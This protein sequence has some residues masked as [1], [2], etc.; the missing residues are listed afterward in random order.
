[1]TFGLPA[2]TTLKI[3]DYSIMK[4]ILILFVCLSMAYLS[5]ARETTF[6][7][8]SPDMA[9]KV[10]VTHTDA[11]FTLHVCHDGKPV[12]SIENISMTVDGTCWN[13]TSSFRK[14]VRTSTERELHP[15]APRKFSVLEDCHN[16]LSLEYRDYA[17]QVRVY[18]EGLAYRFC[19]KS[20]R[21]GTV[22]SESAEFVFPPECLS[23]TQLTDKL[24][25][26]FEF[27]Y[28]VQELASLPQDKFS[29]MPVMVR[30]GDCNIL[31][32]ETDLYGYA[33]SYLKPTGE[34]FGL[35]SV[36]YPAEEDWYEGSNKI[37]VTER[38]N[39]IV[40]T[41]LERNF[42]W[43]IAG[44]Y[45]SDAEILA[46]T[47]PDMV[48]GQ[49]EGDWSWVKPGK[50]LWDWWNG[51]NIYGVDFEAG[52]NT[53][54]YMYMVDYAAEH[55][56]EY[57]LIDEGWSAKES[58]LEL[59]PGVDIPAI[60]AHAAEK[61]VGVIL[62]S[63]WLNVDREMD[64]AFALLKSWGVAGLKIDWMDRNDAKMV[65][66]YER[67][68]KKAGEY[69]LLID[70]H[71]SYP[72]DGMEIRYPGLLTREGVYGLENSRWR[73]DCTPQHQ[74]SIP[75]IRQW[76]G[77]MDFTPGSML[78]A[79]PESFSPV[80]DEPMSMGT[81]CHQIAMY[82]VYESPL[83]MVSDSP[84][85]YDENPESLDFISK[86]PTVWDETVPLMGKIGEVAGV[87]RRSGQNWFIG[88]MNGNDAPICVEIP[89][90]FL[91]DGRY[92]MTLFSD[93]A[94]A[95]LNAKDHRITGSAVSASD[96]LK[97]EL[98]RNGGAA[99]MLEMDGTA[100]RK[101]AA[102]ASA[103][104]AELLSK[105]TLREKIAQLNQ[106]SL[107]E[108]DNVNNLGAPIDQV[109]AEIGSLIYFSD[110]AVLRNEMQRRAVEETRL[111][112]PILFGYDVIHGFRTIYPIPLAI[113]ASWNPG[114]AG[115][116]CRTAAQ[117][118]YDAGINWTFSPMVDI[119]RD[120]RWG[121]I[122]E[123]YGED[124]YLTSVFGAAAVKAYQGD[125]LSKPYNIAACLKHYVGY[126]A[127]EA[128]RDY[129]PSEISRQTLWDTYLPPFEAG[130]RAGAATVMSSF[131]NI[132]G[133]PGS[134]NHYTL[135][136]ILKEK[137]AHDGFVV[138]D[139]DA[140]MQLINQGMAKDGKEAAMYALN[141]GVD[142][143]MVDDL[144][145]RHLEELVDEGKVSMERIDDA[146]HRILALKFELGL[147]ENPYTEEKP[148]NE[149]VL[150]PESLEVAMKLAEES[151]VLLK[152]EG[153]VLP[154]KPGQKVALIGPM[155]KNQADL[156]GSWHGRGRAEDV[157]SIFDGLSDV[158]GE[159]PAFAM[160]CS[161]DGNDTTGFAEAVKTA[162][163]ADVAVLCLG[164]KFN[165]S[166]ENASRSDISLPEIQEKLLMAVKKAGKPVVV[167]L[168][169]GRALD[170]THISPAADAVLEI[171]QPGVTGG[172]AVASILTGKTNP[173]GR[174]TVT[175][176]YTTGQIP[177][178]YNQ[179]TP[180][181]TGAKGRYQDIP[182]TPMYEFGYGLSY[183]TY[184]YGTLTVSADSFT[185]NDTV[186]ATVTVSNTGEMDG[187]ETV[188][189]YISD[190]YSV[191]TRPVKELKHF[192]KRL[193]KA[194]ETQ[195][196]TF[197]I[198]PMRDLSF[199][200]ADGE[201]YI[202]PGDYYIIVKDRKV[203]IT[204]VE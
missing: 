71:G 53:E 77:P 109:P 184:D 178:Y 44:I 52:I 151:M 42:P 169:N 117:E 140:V 127:S 129:V 78:N 195:T 83:Q 180:G 73:T 17:F 191:I 33:G 120:A 25:N 201:R 6:T 147:F 159:A 133:T 171:W 89:L 105:M 181:R 49:A 146:V 46:G 22:D 86:I 121:R 58:L 1:M 124:P 110:D 2:N 30:N 142:M 183:T 155:A 56:L 114:L 103:R 125:D 182:S 84:S 82:I 145:T 107:G 85:K 40:R 116:A 90:D 66:F 144:Y 177:I 158:L 32:S 135:T 21:E 37:Y 166:G 189:W 57:I 60:C 119:A 63:K 95:G 65:D 106:Y 26:W 141:S 70:F 203:R 28:T 50:A 161:F 93:G 4:R 165:W 34:G 20:D 174:L 131:N 79:Q 99:A 16:E 202:E 24:Q 91:G 94:N 35:M 23:Y 132:S 61:G 12:F 96:V 153:D 134:A 100:V 179:R 81:R 173:S 7:V 170:L 204:L 92:G 168:S 149:R 163:E 152:N 41:G 199:V 75:F 160:G 200:N 113:G 196:F 197:E 10:S 76:A 64:E 55:G 87:A 88:V 80:P 68:L 190:P 186:T 128:G 136:E 130:I 18:N 3:N 188:Q 112:I 164:E 62:W 19:G 69:Q 187:K 108:N 38:E 126:G 154:L 15:V 104:A 115:E 27:H 111:G 13:G 36:D 29:L 54:T 148:E 198:D 185:V 51:H 8:T 176:P 48:S 118:A 74:V 67:V 98:A 123:G 31:I 122:A 150:L 39:Y 138:S 175:F 47:L 14:A 97:L 192:E 172:P 72:P 162:S 167:L 137:W 59:A 45:D 102:S 43:R 101:G 193:I 156:L 139:W 9:D 11:G 5:D 194:G 143:D 157:V